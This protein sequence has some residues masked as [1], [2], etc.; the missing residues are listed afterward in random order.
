MLS[1]AGRASAA[2]VSS[3]KLLKSSSRV[4]EQQ[5][6]LQQEAWLLGQ[7]AECAVVATSLG[8]VRISSSGSEQQVAAQQAGTGGF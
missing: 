2:P 8:N 5:L 7:L 4:Q 1:A 3:S 6:Q